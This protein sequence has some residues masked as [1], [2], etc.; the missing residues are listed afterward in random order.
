MAEKH[1]GS[2]VTEGAVGDRL[3]LARERPGLTQGEVHAR[4][5]IGVSS[6]SDFEKGKRAPS[7]DQLSTLARSYDRPGIGG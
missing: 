7:P 3:R 6:P 5:G 1:G 4:T 2:G